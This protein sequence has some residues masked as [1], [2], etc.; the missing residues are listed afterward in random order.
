MLIIYIIKF[1]DILNKSLFT[2]PF[3]DLEHAMLIAKILLQTVSINISNNW[4]VV[5]DIH[6]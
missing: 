1:T 4:T 5:Q 2:M 3:T 6:T